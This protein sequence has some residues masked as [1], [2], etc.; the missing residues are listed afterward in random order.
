MRYQIRRSA[1]V[2]RDII[3]IQPGW[4]IAGLVVDNPSGSWLTLDLPYGPAFIP[5]YT[6]GFATAIAPAAQVIGVRYTTGPTDLVSS[7]AGD[8]FVVYVFDNPVANNAGTPFI[9]PAP[10]AQFFSGTFT[11]LDNAVPSASV[12]IPAP[13]ATS[14][15]RILFASVRGNVPAQSNITLEDTILNQRFGE[16]TISSVE[17]YQETAFG[18]G[19]DLPIGAGVRLNYASL[20]G[21]QS[22]E[23]VVLYVVV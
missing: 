23:V 22:L 8:P 20:W 16:L 14:R 21:V 19:L 18:V 10:E 13:S 6:L 5:P 3:G 7:T 15:V 11:T 4:L 17:A 1:S 12:I 9:T 2:G